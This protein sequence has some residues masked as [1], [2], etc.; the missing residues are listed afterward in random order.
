MYKQAI[1]N[2]GNLT[3]S[4]IAYAEAIKNKKK[5]YDNASN[6]VVG[7]FKDAFNEGLKKN[8]PKMRKDM[9]RNIDKS[10]AES[11]IPNLIHDLVSGITGKNRKDTAVRLRATPRKVVH[12]KVPKGN[13]YRP[14]TL[15]DVLSGNLGGHSKEE[16]NV[17][18]N[19]HLKDST[20]QALKA[21]ADSKTKSFYET[22]MNHRFGRAGTAKEKVDAAENLYKNYMDAIKSNIRASGNIPNLNK[23]KKTL[24]ETEKLIS[25]NFS[26]NSIHGIAGGVGAGTGAISR[27]FLNRGMGGEADRIRGELSNKGFVG[28]L[29]TGNETAL[30]LKRLGE[31]E[32]GLSGKGLKYLGSAGSA[33]AV[34]AAGSKLLS[35]LPASKTNNLIHAGGTGLGILGAATIPNVLNAVKGRKYRSALNDLKK[36]RGTLAK[37]YAGLRRI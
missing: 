30:Q 22:L 18:L 14:L 17:I 12:T 11:N 28:R 19:R 27:S 5:F 20:E 6:Y 32:K 34:G 25:K 1:G 24:N 33:G 9:K 15:G 21:G 8:M 35:L 16:A 36:S 23:T 2:N 7:N 29:L 31:L 26:R 4:E 10:I 3:N 13:P 37:M